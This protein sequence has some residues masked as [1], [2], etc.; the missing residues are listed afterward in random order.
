MEGRAGQ[1]GCQPG[2]LGAPG[3]RPGPRRTARVLTERIREDAREQTALPGKGKS[4]TEVRRRDGPGLLL[5]P[6]A[7]GRE[8]TST[9]RDAAAAPPR[10][11]GQPGGCG[12]GRRLK[13]PWLLLGE[14]LR[15]RQG[16]PS[17]PSG[18]E[19]LREVYIFLGKSRDYLS[20]LLLINLSCAPHPSMV[21]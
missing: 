17:R 1:C 19:I 15:W 14:R 9:G 11:P 8:E 5:T 20:E 18:P 13:T 10:P 6:A 12:G 3:L 16:N 7:G 4:I 21:F 2:V